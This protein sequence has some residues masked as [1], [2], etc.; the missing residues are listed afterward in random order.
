MS[1]ARRFRG[2][3]GLA[4]LA[5]AL[6]P[7]EAAAQPVKGP[8]DQ[9]PPGPVEAPP[10]P[11]PFEPALDAQAAEQ[12]ALP[13][14]SGPAIARVVID[15]GQE[16]GAAVP[17]PGWTPPLD[18]GGAL[19]LDYAPGQALDAAWVQAQFDTAM[20]SGPLP[21][22][23]AVAL[24]Q[25]INRAFVGAG[26]INSGIL[27]DGR[28]DDALKLRLVLGRIGGSDSSAP[29]MT[30]E[31][32]GN[33]SRG[34]SADYILARFESARAAPLSA[35]ALERDFRLLDESPAIESI[36][37]ALSPGGNPGEASLRLIVNPAQRF[38]LYAGA[39]NDRS[40]SV[41]GERLFAGGYFRNLL[42]SGDEIGFEGGATRGVE[43][44]QA[45]YTAPLFNTPL[46]LSLR[47][48][49][50]NAA[51]I[52]SA[53]LPLDIKARDR[54]A[55]AGLTYS[56]LAEPLMVRGGLGRW[57]PSEALSVGAHW[58]AR[59]QKSFLL[60]QPFS[61][62][63]GSVDGRSEFDAIALSADYLRRD[64]QRVIAVSLAAT[65]G[66]GGTRSNIPAIPNPHRQFMALLG[67]L[68]FAQR[69]GESFELRGRLT[70][71]HS[72]GTLYSGLRLSVGGS[73]TVRGYRENLFLV[74]RGAIGSLE[75]A[76]NFNL[77]GESRRSGFEWD[78]FSA[79]TFVDGAHFRNAEKPQPGHRW[80]A[81][82]GLGL[83]WTPSRAFNASVAYGHALKS[84]EVAGDKNMQDRGIHFRI[85]TR[86]LAMF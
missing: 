5:L 23:R 44:G 34:L 33:R 61:F 42:S 83:A 76:R 36:S 30:V 82:A 64:Q 27:V 43:D 56:L 31:F 16:S 70:A 8:S 75:L 18:K 68:N 26:F 78:S 38:D 74:D 62:A 67:Q 24:V 46:S 47:G 52:T 72:R 14:D 77:G 2:G 80:I 58:I 51:V 15:S 10:A 4:A 40:P 3:A 49:F 9:V 39:S 29:A 45:R 1:G 69:I 13:S 41:G 84:V 60:G 19:A 86:P 6:S 73:A 85:V 11:S 20:A 81:S 53:L 21:P 12:A 35:F 54:S 25:L 28:E 7:G 57:S 37:A 63:P 32:Q 66:L 79:F 71:Q 48:S 22:S 55:E 65:V 50:N 59:R 17:P